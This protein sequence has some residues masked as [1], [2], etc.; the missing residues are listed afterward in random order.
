MSL[1]LHTKL[2]EPSQLE[3][4]EK[5]ID[6][7]EVLSFLDEEFANKTYRLIESLL[8]QI[9]KGLIINFSLLEELNVSIEKTFIRPQLVK[10]SK[11][12][13]SESFKRADFL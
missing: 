3:N 6:Y 10:G 4:L 12:F 8:Y 5:T 13:V 7:G 11:I 1:T 2:S 9:A